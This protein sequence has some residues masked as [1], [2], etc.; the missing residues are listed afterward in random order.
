MSGHARTTNAMLNEAEREDIDVA[1]D[2]KRTAEADAVDELCDD[3]AEIREGTDAECFADALL[4]AETSLRAAASLR[5]DGET[6]PEAL[7]EAL[8]NG[9]DD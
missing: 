7:H 8:F 9:G 2:A 6:S 3:L 1:A 4:E 5:R